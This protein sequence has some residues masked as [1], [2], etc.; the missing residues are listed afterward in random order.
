MTTNHRPLRKW[1][2][3][4][5]AL[6]GALLSPSVAR[7]AVIEITPADDLQASVSAL[8]PGDELVLGGGTY[9]LSQR[10]AID[11]QGTAAMPIIIRAKD[12]ETAIITRPDANQNTINVENAAY[13]ELRGLEVV[14]GSHGIRITASSFITIDGCHVHDTGDVGISAN[15]PGSS[16]DHLT[17]VNNHIHNTAGT[18]EGM[19]LGCNDNGC[20][21][22]DS[23][24]AG[25]WIH[26]TR[27]PAVSQGDGIEVKEG[28]YNNV[29]RDN[30]IHD[31]NYPCIITYSTV[32]N[33]AANVI[34]RNALWNCGDHGIQSAADAIIRNNIILSAAA[35]GIRNQP[36]QAGAPANL[37]IVH[38]TVLKAAGDAIRSDGIVGSVTIANNAL[39]APAGNAIRV[40]GDLSALTVEANVGVGSLN[41]LAAGFDASGDLATDFV[42]AS[43]SGAPP[44]DVFPKAGSHL[45]GAAAAAYVPS[46]D[47]NGTSRAATLDVGA[48]VY[49]D[50]NPGWTL[51]AGFKDTVTNPGTGGA[52]G[53]ASSGGAGAGGQS[54][55]SGGAG[56]AGGSGS[57]GNPTGADDGC[58]CATP[59]ASPRTGG[60]LFGLLAFGA[61]F[62]RARRAAKRRGA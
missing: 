42:A 12:G 51:G 31:T 61:L 10:F 58:G 57:D 33:G 21:M 54:S 9:N 11:V 29:I 45:V 24:I 35:D 48:Y 60:V 37:T 17:I 55:S 56:G 25:N 43:L 38:N 34:E 53:G 4:G 2:L 40:G 36:H 46:D 27:G 7:A 5:A 1:G 15:V 19:Y 30:V 59:G 14:G 50:A 22:H 52:G 44:N 23:L 18:G 6:A 32:G 62:G 13:V 47:F 49:D 28:S 20:Q 41:G 3:A 8:N 16:Y 39:Y 26:E